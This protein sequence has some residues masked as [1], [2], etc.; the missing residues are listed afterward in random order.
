[1][2]KSTMT[3]A[4]YLEQGGT[5]CPFCKSHD[6]EGQEVNIDAGT[7]WQDVSCNQCGEEWQDTYTLTG[8]ATT[9]K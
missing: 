3:S 4:E 6:I 8:Y 9:N 7:A 5:V 2:N 1:M